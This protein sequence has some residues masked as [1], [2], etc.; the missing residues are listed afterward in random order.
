VGLINQ[1]PTRKTDGVDE[2]GPCV[3]RIKALQEKKGDNGPGT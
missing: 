3:R 1:T 2:S